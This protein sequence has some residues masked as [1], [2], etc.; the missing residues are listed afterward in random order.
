MKCP[1]C[2]YNS[3]EFLDACKKCGSALGSFKKNHR[4]GAVLFR[5]AAVAEA[6]PADPVQEII[7]VESPAPPQSQAAPAVEDSPAQVL[8]EPGITAQQ[9]TP[10]EGFEL[11]LP[12]PSQDEAQDQDLDDF[13][14]ANELSP[15]TAESAFPESADYD[16]SFEE[17]AEEEQGTENRDFD[18]DEDGSGMEDYERLIEPAAI[19][20]EGGED[21]LDKSD[22]GEYFGTSNFTFAPESED[23]F[24]TEGEP[25]AEP[26]VEKK[27][28]PNLDDF[29]K[30]FDMIFDIDDSSDSREK[31]S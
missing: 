4:I 29:E 25:T 5:S 7:S 23:I 14:F 21:T 16:F 26:G 11:D 15:P 9:E 10:F 31:T 6:S 30:E 2:G 19:D 18:F 27:A 17:P 24:S 12:E 20:S 13:S 3:F 8:Q 1:K 22:D 28:Q